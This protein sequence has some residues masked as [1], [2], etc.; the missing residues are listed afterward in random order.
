MAINRAKVSHGDTIMGQGY[1]AGTEENN[2]RCESI[3]GPACPDDD[4]NEASG[5]GEGFVHI[6][7]GISGKADLSFDYNWNNPM[8]RVEIM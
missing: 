8:M 3:P 2:E 1:D 6:H 4:G 7:R 5:N